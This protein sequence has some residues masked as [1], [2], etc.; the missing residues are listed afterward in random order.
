M[1]ELTAQAVLL[2]IEGTTS[3]V[4]FVYDVMFPFV[5]RELEGYLAAA[6]EEP[7]L[8]QTCEQIAIDA[9]HAS[10]DEWAGA[11]ADAAARQALVR[12]EVVRLMDGDIKATGLKQLQGLIW[13]SGFDSGELQA[14]VYDDTPEALQH[15]SEARLDVRIYSSGSIAAQKLFFG[16]TIAGNLLPW[17]RGHYDTTTGP[18]KEPHSYAQ[19]AQDF[20][21]SPQ[22][23]VFFS[24]VVAELDAARTAGLQTVLLTR[25][26]N[27]PVV[28]EHT[29][30]TVSRFDEVVVR[31]E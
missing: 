12:D 9:G 11:E 25:P 31:P 14:H 26:G 8:Q 5:R 6:W 30:H 10:L 27:A 15:W 19:I 16:H 4:S 21:L 2:D 1:I 29:H 17:F 13:R 23:I 18:K 28:G 24:D 22:E 7:D 3:S 20:S